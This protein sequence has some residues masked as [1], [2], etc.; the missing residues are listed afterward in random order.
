MI[1]VLDVE[2]DGYEHGPER[3]IL[4][5]PPGVGKTHNVMHS[6]LVPA[7]TAGARVLATTFTKAGATEMRTRL[8]AL[9]PTLSDRELKAT[10]RTIHSEAFY[11]CRTQSDG[12]KLLKDGKREKD[13]DDVDAPGWESMM[14][15]CDDLR[16]EAIRVW[17]LARSVLLPARTGDSIAAMVSEVF[18]RSGARK[19]KHGFSSSRVA[20]EVEA[21]E[22]EKRAAGL[23]DFT[24]LLVRALSCSAPTRDMILIDEAQDLAPLQIAL[25][26]KWS[27]RARKVLLV[28][29]PDQGIYAF[30]G[31]DG[32][33]LTTE[34]RAGCEARRLPKSR[35][36]PRAAHA[37]ARNL[38]SRN[39]DR[40]D[41]PYEPADRDGSVTEFWDY[42]G[43]L[44]G[45]VRRVEAADATTAFVLARCRK[46]LVRYAKALEEDGVPFV[47]ERCGS[48]MNRKTVV[49]MVLAVADFL[50]TGMMDVGAALR[51]AGE[52]KV[53]GAAW[54][55]GTKKATEDA[56][57]KLADE[58]ET[59]R[60]DGRTLLACGLDLSTLR[61]TLTEAASL[62]RLPDLEP[63]VRIIERR[64]IAGL[65][66]TP[67][68]AL[69]TY[70]G[71]KGREADVVLVDCEAAFPVMREA[72]DSVAGCEG[73]R[74][75]LYVAVTRTRDVL[76]L[77]RG[78]MR[79]QACMVELTR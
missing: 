15:P 55:T 22:E 38:I 78:G 67:R 1:P 16:E 23:V 47:G 10:C 25:V 6:W 40:V 48:P 32:R 19:A 50:E 34:I 37:L 57:K 31:A 29:D 17:A 4:V 74:R 8:A 49:G 42:R 44:L 46:E 72:E 30:S 12:V 5:G 71:S 39:V 27:E 51:L 11:L 54:F 66:E 59:Q 56:L 68:I 73:E 9:V 63:Y 64:G 79:K 13:D 43:A 26:N 21:Y 14:S 69:T 18:S 33:Y 35:R 20:I 65:R 52:L 77:V 70:H 61:G 62:L 41:S 28:G 2:R 36:V 45:L 3:M 7:T 75:C 60:V 53:R 24:D 76:M 58:D